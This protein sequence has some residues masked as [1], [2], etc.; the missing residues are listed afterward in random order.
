MIDGSWE[1]QVRRALTVAL[2]V[3]LW[4]THDASPTTIYWPDPQAYIALRK[5]RAISAKGNTS[6]KTWERAPG[7]T[8][9]TSIAPPTT[10]STG[11]R[12]LVIV[13]WPG[14]AP[15]AAQATGTTGARKLE[16]TRPAMTAGPAAAQVTPKAVEPLAATGM[17]VGGNV[18]RR[19]RAQAMDT[20]GETTH[21]K[22]FST[23]LLQ[24]V[25]GRQQKSPR[26]RDHGH[27]QQEA[28]GSLAN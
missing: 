2:V 11:T 13:L 15:I 24:L 26:L 3:N 17:E 28:S 18:G 12:K 10:E 22:T 6:S 9:P 21:E 23:R 19:R 1:G 5:R 4:K 14:T 27:R 20:T 16:G 8:T 7:W 25:H